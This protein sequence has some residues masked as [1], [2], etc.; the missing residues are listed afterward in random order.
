MAACHSK[1][2]PRQTRRER[3]LLYILQASLRTIPTG[4]PALQSMHRRSSDVNRS[5]AHTHTHTHCVHPRLLHIPPTPPQPLLASF[6]RCL[7]PLAES[8]RRR[9]VGQPRSEGFRR[10]EEDAADADAEAAAAAERRRLQ[11]VAVVSLHRAEGSCFNTACIDRK[12][13]HIWRPSSSSSSSYS[14]TSG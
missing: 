8:R 1:V 13:L 6:P 10:R 3:L 4:C 7:N 5:A 11:R 9:D 12:I 2:S 14:H